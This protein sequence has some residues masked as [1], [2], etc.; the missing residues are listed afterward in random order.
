MSSNVNYILT[1]DQGTTSSRAVLIDQKGQIVDMV[2][3]ELTQYFPQPGWV[4]HDPLEIWNTQLEVARK[5]LRKNKINVKEIAGLGITNQRETTIVWDRSSGIPL[6]RAIVWQDRRTSEH[7]GKLK[8]A[9]LTA[10]IRERSGLVLDAYFSATKLAWILDNVPEVRS[11]AI[12]GELAFGNVDSWLIWNLTGGKVHATDVTNASR[13]MLFNINKLNWDNKLLEIFDVPRAILPE[14]KSS[15]EVYGQTDPSLFGS[16]ITIC[17]VAGDQQAA[18]FGGCCLRKGMVKNTYGTGCFMVMNTGHKPVYSQHNLL[19]TIGWSLGDS[20]IY[21]LEGSVFTGGSVVQWLRDG[22]GLIK[23]S[24]EV[25]TLAGEVAYNGGVYFVPAFTGLG[26]PHWD[27]YARGTIAGLTRGS[28]AGHLAR[29]A[30][31]AIAFQTYDV[32]EAMKAD[33]GI[34]PIELRVDGGAAVNNLLMQFQADILGIKVVRPRILE[35]TAIGA[36]YLAGLAVKFWKD[37][38]EIQ[39]NW[40]AERSFMPGMDEKHRASLLKGWKEAVKCARS[41]YP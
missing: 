24:F 36:G 39:A 31:E 16:P 11:R 6:Y 13:T 8:S 26:A 4:E 1:F 19:S 40:Q 28:T 27:Q 17:G 10:G 3:E 12:H 22:L 21:A 20:T 32:L 5:L 29:A 7:C 18:L 35:S 38:E 37:I 9:G 33:S 41:F 14:V 2:Q 23:D 30:L 15:S 25:E 34:E